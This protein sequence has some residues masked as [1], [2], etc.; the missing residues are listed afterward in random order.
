MAK[1]LTCLEWSLNMRSDKTAKPHD[2]FYQAIRELSPCP[3]V[4]FLVETVKGNDFEVEGYTVVAESDNPIGNS[5]RIAIRSDLLESGE[6]RVLQTVGQIPGASFEEAPHYA[7]A[8]VL[9]NGRV[10]N[11]IATRVLICSGRSTVEEYRQRGRQFD[12]LA[13]HLSTLENPVV[14]GDFNHGRILGTEQTSAEMIRILYDD[15]LQ[16]Q[17]GYFYQYICEELG[18]REFALRTPELY[19]SCGPKVVGDT[20]IAGETPSWNY[21][22]DHLIMRANSDA[23][24]LA[25]LRY[26]WRH[27]E[28]EVKKG[29][30]Q[31]ILK[32]KG[33]PDHA[34]L[35]AEIMVKDNEESEAQ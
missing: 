28:W 9:F 20:V 25:D 26:D 16:V 18:A 12:L 7:Q 34:M 33:F 3:N 15:C 35:V 29:A 30:T 27:L 4:L 11:L 32:K 31:D 14:M 13:K 2:V 19:V 10:L 17:G 21:K 8:D 6:M 5:V 24:T 23:L 22:I 1:K